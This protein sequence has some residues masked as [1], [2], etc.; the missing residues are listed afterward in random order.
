MFWSNS[1]FNSVRI[2]R[3]TITTIRILI[4]FSSNTDS[5]CYLG[6]KFEGAKEAVNDVEAIYSGNAMSQAWVKHFSLQ[7]NKIMADSIDVINSGYLVVSNEE[8]DLYG[9]CLHWT[10]ERELKGDF[11]KYNVNDGT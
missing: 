2:G 10:I 6:G 8:T 7:W 5:S 11:T 1:Q 9:K 3:N 4:N